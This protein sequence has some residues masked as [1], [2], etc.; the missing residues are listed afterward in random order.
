MSEF[1]N[2]LGEGQ[3]TKAQL[4]YKLKIKMV[5]R[6]AV[7]G[8]LLFGI[9]V[10]T[11]EVADS[12]LVVLLNLVLL[13]DLGEMAVTRMAGFQLHLVHMT[14]FL[15]QCKGLTSVIHTI[16]ISTSRYMGLAFQ[17]IQKL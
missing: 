5:G 14:C 3:E 6:S 15:L 10:P 9:V 13:P 7:V 17:K 11:P 12:S 4:R 1:S 16:E 8:Q 2:R